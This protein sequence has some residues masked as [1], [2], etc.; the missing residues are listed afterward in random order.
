MG[1]PTAVGK[2]KAGAVRKTSYRLSRSHSRASS[3]ST[4]FS[5]SVSPMC[6][7]A[8]AC[9]G[10][11][12]DVPLGSTSTAQL[13]Q[14]T[15]ATSCSTK[16][17]AAFLGGPTELTL[18]ELARRTGYPTPTVHRLLATLEHA[19]WVSR[20]RAGGYL[21]TLHIAELARHVLAG[22]NLRDQA[23]TAMQDLSQRTGARGDA[24]LVAG[25][26]PGVGVAVA[27]VSQDQQGLAGGVE[28]APARPD[29]LSVGADLVGQPAQGS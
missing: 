6:T 20:G 3:S 9:R 1:E 11:M 14:A 27:Q 15:A 29:G 13:S 12:M 18:T 5:P 22:I 25:G 7:I 19:G 21:L 28:L 23:L 10:S 16:S 17:V 2:V 4:K 24:E 26:Q 8:L